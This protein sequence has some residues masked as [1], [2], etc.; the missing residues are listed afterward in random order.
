M[1]YSTNVQPKC[2]NCLCQKENDKGRAHT[3]RHTD[4]RYR[5]TS[6]FRT[7]PLGQLLL[8]YARN[9]IQFECKY[10]FTNAGAVPATRHPPCPPTPG[11]TAALASVRAEATNYAPASCSLS[12]PSLPFHGH[13]PV[14]SGSGLAFDS[15]AFAAFRLLWLLYGLLAALRW[16]CWP[17]LPSFK[18]FFPRGKC[19]K[20]E[21]EESSR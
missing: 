10:V 11:V 15:C 18:L 3:H 4:T 13:S 16:C 1:I 6:A 7:F 19:R 2:A 12:A 14:A 9:S 5:C 17:S 21:R 8:D 20:I